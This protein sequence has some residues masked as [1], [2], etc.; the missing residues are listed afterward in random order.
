[1]DKIWNSEFSFQDDDSAEASEIVAESTI[2][3]SKGKI[4]KKY[5]QRYLF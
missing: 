4:V 2:G 5:N 3:I 1:M